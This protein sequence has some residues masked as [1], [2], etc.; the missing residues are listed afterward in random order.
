M[1]LSTTKPSTSP[2][3]T[4]SVLLL[5]PW[6][7][8]IRS[9]FAVITKYIAYYGKELLSA[10]SSK[11]HA[12]S[13]IEHLDIIRTPPSF[14][15]FLSWNRLRWNVRNIVFYRHG[16]NRITMCVLPHKMIADTNMLHSLML[17]RIIRKML[18]RLVIFFDNCRVHN[19]MSELYEHHA[20][21][22]KPLALKRQAP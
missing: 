19:R 5:P 11:A 1:E 13:L 6:R 8:Q 20:L 7:P 2:R 9:E 3:L 18:A 16:M 15:K 4:H 21:L 10:L 17:S 22:L 14:Y 12:I